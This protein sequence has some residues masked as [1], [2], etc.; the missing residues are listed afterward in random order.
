MKTSIAILALALAMPTLG[1]C[2]SSVSNPVA[3]NPAASQDRAGKSDEKGPETK[4]QNPTQP[5]GTP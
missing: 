1:A 4:S 5:V 2:T 3:S